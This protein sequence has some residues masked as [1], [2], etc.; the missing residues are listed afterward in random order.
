MS[1]ATESLRRTHEMFDNGYT[2]LADVPFDTIGEM[3]R[4]APHMI[5]LRNYLSVYGAV[6]SCSK[7]PR[8]RQVFTFQNRC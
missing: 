5:R 7:D 8:L 3:M 6:A 4:A 2:Q 1:M